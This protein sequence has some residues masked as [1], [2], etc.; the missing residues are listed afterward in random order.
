MRSCQEVLNTE[1]TSDGIL[2]ATDHWQSVLSFIYST[3]G[4]GPSIFVST[5]REHLKHVWSNPSPFVYFCPPGCVNS[6]IA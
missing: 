3:M 6:I 5:P 2:C 4:N 1:Q